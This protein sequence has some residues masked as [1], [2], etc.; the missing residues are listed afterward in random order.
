M[1]SQTKRF[2]FEIFAPPPPLLHP[3]IPTNTHAHIRPLE[4]GPSIRLNFFEKR[5]LLCYRQNRQ[6]NP[7]TLIYMD[8]SCKDFQ[9]R[10]LDY[11][12]K[13]KIERFLVQ[14]YFV[15]NGVSCVYINQHSGFILVCKCFFCVYT[16]QHS[17]FL[18]SQMFRFVE[19][20]KICKLMGLQLLGKYFYPTSSLLCPAC[21]CVPL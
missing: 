9:A 21:A 13:I 16:N 2:T 8:L 5:L 20:F 1:H 14:V 15:C 17:R 11:W 7:K 18:N 3:I 12:F 4:K 6:K 19:F 10:I